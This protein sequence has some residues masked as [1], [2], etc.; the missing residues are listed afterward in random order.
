MENYDFFF[1]PPYYHD[2]SKIQSKDTLIQIFAELWKLMCFVFNSVAV[3]TVGLRVTG[4]CFSLQMKKRPLQDE[5][6]WFWAGFKIKQKISAL[7]CV[8]YRNDDNAQFFFSTRVSSLSAETAGG[9]RARKIFKVWGHVE[10]IVPKCVSVHPCVCESLI[11][12]S[13]IPNGCVSQWN[14]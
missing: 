12:G 1:T 14:T 8:L 2:Y 7:Q 6:L 11:P 10:F 5:E 4:A 9:G 13:T 3:V